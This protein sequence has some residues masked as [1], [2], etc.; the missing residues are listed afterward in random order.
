MQE[1]DVSVSV[2]HLNQG[3]W[4]KF[5][6][7]ARGGHGAGFPIEAQFDDLRVSNGKTEAG[8]STLS[9]SGRGAAAILDE[10]VKCLDS[11]CEQV[12]VEISSL[13]RAR[14]ESLL[15]IVEKLNAK[16]LVLVSCTG[17]TFSESED[18]FSGVTLTV[19][20][21]AIG[22]LPELVNPLFPD[23]N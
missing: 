18:G 21:G 4:E 5:L 20:E 1:W 10:F 6:S 22:S 15:K 19:S 7:Q 14:F 2:Q 16:D 3:Q 13:T 11:S 17:V 23:G 8:Y 9:G 12:T